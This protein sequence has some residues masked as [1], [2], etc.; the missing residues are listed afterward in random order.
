MKLEVEPKESF[1]KTYTD[2]I[3]TGSFFTNEKRGLVGSNVSGS[4]EYLGEYGFGA[5][6]FK[7]LNQ[8]YRSSVLR[9]STMFNSTKIIYDSIMPSFLQI[10]AL[11]GGK[12]VAAK[13]DDQSWYSYMKQ[14]YPAVLTSSLESPLL[15]LIISTDGTVTTGDATP[16]SDN[17]W[18]CEYPFMHK[19]SNI[20]RTNNIDNFNAA[21]LYED[22]MVGGALE[23]NMVTNVTSSN[24]FIICFSS[25][26]G[27]SP[28]KISGVYESYFFPTVNSVQQSPGTVI[29]TTLGAPRSEEVLKSFFGFNIAPSYLLSTGSSTTYERFFGI[30]ISGWKYGIYSGIPTSPKVIFRIGKYGQFRDILEQRIYTKTISTDNSFDTP[31][32]IS[33]ISGTNA[34]ITASNPQ[35]LNLNGSGF[36]DFES[37]TCQPFVDR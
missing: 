4:Q 23:F 19:Y 28:V 2:R 18:N 10:Y 16:I 22:S 12:L 25:G 9:G 27:V 30:G 7:F 35:T 36:F 3:I 34:F 21:A 29:K 31:V 32:V 11:N 6:Y 26:S 33:F 37:K 8:D 17:N 1:Y 24:K 13:W 15:K 20:S 14:V 5:Y